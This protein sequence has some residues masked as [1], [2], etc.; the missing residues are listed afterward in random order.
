MK[1]QI[2]DVPIY[3]EEDIEN[4]CFTNVT[5]NSEHLINLNHFSAI[6]RLFRVTAMVFKF[7]SYLKQKV[8]KSEGSLSNSRIID[9]ALNDLLD[10]EQY[11]V[12][13]L[14]RDC[15]SDIFEYFQ[16]GEC[17]RIPTLV[18]QLQL[19]VEDGIL[20]CSRR[21]VEANW[22]DRARHPVLLP[23]RHHFTTLIIQD[24]HKR[25]LHGGLS[26]AVSEIRQR[27][28]VPRCRRRVKSV[29]NNCA[30]CKKVTGKPYT[31]PP[32]APLPSFRLQETRPFQVVGL[33]YTGALTVKYAGREQKVYVA[34][35]TCTR[36]RAAH[37]ELVLDNSTDSFLQAFRRFISRRSKPSLI[38]SDNAT[39]FVDASKVLKKLYDDPKVKDSMLNDRIEW[40][41]VTPRLPWEGGFYERMIALVKVSLKKCLGKAFVTHEEMSTLIAEVE[42]VINDKPLAYIGE[43]IRDNDP[44]TPS[45]LLLGYCHRSPCNRKMT[46]EGF[47]RDSFC[48]HSLSAYETSC[49]FNEF[50]LQQVSERIFVCI[51]GEG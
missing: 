32:H 2:S 1:N 34:L 11:W 31:Q 28:W 23:S 46:L 7:I 29:L 4:V 5:Q 27:W 40:H 33:D 42:A 36:I 49:I 13:I 25:T 6:G 41:F 38:I 9:I 39:S 35:F 43:D 18:K 21:Y 24:C 48:Q 19:K 22:T 14:Q 47:G 10:A 8:G 17:S 15:F 51:K 44:V 50:F 30:V 26:M 45:Q 12:G 16:E 37:L 20:R 3:H